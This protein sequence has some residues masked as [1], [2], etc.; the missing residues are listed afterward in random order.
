MFKNLVISSFLG[1]LAVVLGA[2]G[3]HYLK[4]ILTVEQLESF[5]TAVQYQM[6]HAIVLLFV[7]GTQVFDIL[8]KKKMTIFFVLG[9]LFFSGSIYCIQLTPINAKTIWF[10]TPLG[11][12]FFI[13]G[14]LYMCYIFL[15]KSSNITK[16]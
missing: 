1:F 14:W 16:K 3:T 8:E 9:I 10:V 7:N 5:Q 15:K 12:L 13:I 6:L 11:G 2:F 4:K